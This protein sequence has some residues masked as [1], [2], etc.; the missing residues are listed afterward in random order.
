MAK[1]LITES[2]GHGKFGMPVMMPGP[3]QL[4]TYATAVSSTAF[5]E[6][7]NLIRVIADADVYLLFGANPTADAGDIRV[8]ADTVEYFG[9]QPGEKVSCYD[10]SS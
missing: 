6:H 3:T 9:V 2:I 5:A 10:G 7:T 4:V 8:P 1:C